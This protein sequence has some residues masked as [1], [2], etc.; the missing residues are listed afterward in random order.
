M[1]T[2][3]IVDQADIPSSFMAKSVF[4]NKK[5]LISSNEYSSIGEDDVNEVAS[6]L[7]AALNCEITTVVVKRRDLAA[8]I[9]MKSGSYEDFEVDEKNGD[10]DYDEWVKGYSNEDLSHF[11]K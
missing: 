8:H 4:V 5:H 1:S 10:V 9:A 2:I 11:L 3:H 7:A 6:N